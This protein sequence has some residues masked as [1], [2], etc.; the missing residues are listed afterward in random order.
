[1]VKPG[2][3][4]YYIRRVLNDWSDKE[5]IQILGKIRAACIADSRVLVSENL[6][7]DEPSISLAAADIW[8]MNF[9]GKRRDARMFEGLAEQSGFKISG[10][11]KD[12][13]SNA[14]VIEMIP[15]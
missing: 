11:S 13:V 14:A 10:L 1:M 6:L 9:G 3:L 7:P 8:M 4:V 5:C 2:A 12:H 15:I